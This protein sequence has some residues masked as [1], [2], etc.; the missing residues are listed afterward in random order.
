MN[1]L[2][3]IHTEQFEQRLRAI[4]QHLPYPPRPSLT[5]PLPTL[6]PQPGDQIKSKPAGQSRRLTL[7]ISV[8]ALLLMAIFLSTPAA[9]AMLETLQVGIIRIWFGRPTRTA[10]PNA[11]AQSSGL[12]I[13]DL[14]IL[15]QLAGETSLA[16]A[17]RLSGLAL[18]LPAY[19]PGLGEPDRVFLMI[20]DSPMI[21]LVWLDPQEPERALLSLHAYDERAWLGMKYDP[22]E[23][24]EVRVNGELGLWAEGPYLLELRNGEIAIKRLLQGRVLIWSHSGVTYRLESELPLQ[25]A[26]RI[27]ESIPIP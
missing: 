21:V 27:A 9:R 10:T 16:E 26:T 24:Q 1:E 25:E 23:V 22:A 4:A 17:R 12:T 13:N 8:A 20:P 6:R 2:S 3:D 18:P 19:P 14:A 11:T 15:D 5:L 7:M